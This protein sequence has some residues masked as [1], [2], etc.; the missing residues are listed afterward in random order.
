[1]ES[2][3]G[4]E[5]TANRKQISP[6]T[7]PEPGGAMIET[8]IPGRHLS[9]DEPFDLTIE[10]SGFVRGPLIRS[11]GD[12]RVKA[13]CPVSCGDRTLRGFNV[14]LCGSN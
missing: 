7:G 6:L 1:M 11:N 4:T 13:M 3:V 12:L 2:E 8:P 9:A 5:R 10:P 14:T